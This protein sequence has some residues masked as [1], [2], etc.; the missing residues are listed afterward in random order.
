MLRLQI[1]KGERHRIMRNGVRRGSLWVT[2]GTNCYCV[3]VTGETEAILY[4]FLRSDFGAETGEDQGKKYWNV[5][6]IKDVDKIIRQF[7]K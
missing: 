7:D 1:N 6:S 2:P 5:I 3:C 4:D